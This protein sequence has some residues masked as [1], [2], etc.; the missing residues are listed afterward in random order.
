MTLGTVK[1]PTTEQLRDV[2]ADLG[3]TLTDDDLATHLA[4]LA[5]EHRRLQ[6][7]RS[8][9]GRAAGGDL[10]AHAGLSADAARR[11]NTTPGTSS[12]RSRARQR[13]AQGQDRRAEGQHLPRRRADDERRLHAGRL[14]A[15]RRRDRRRRA[16]SM[17]AAPSSARRCASISAS[18]AAA[19]PVP[20]ARCTTRTRWAIRPAARP[21]AAPRWWR[22]ARWTWRSAATRA[23]RSACRRP[24]AASTA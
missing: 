4:A 17:P 1:A 13:Q 16:C 19:T 23:A 8:D 21:P 15:G 2:A 18:P 11:T 22:S 7:R 9:A 6:H 20:P 10:S 3:M 12:P 14:R 5:A 24:I